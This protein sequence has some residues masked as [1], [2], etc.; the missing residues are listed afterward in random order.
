MVNRKRKN[1]GIDE[2]EETAHIP[3]WQESAGKQKVVK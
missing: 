2:D 1:D 3:S